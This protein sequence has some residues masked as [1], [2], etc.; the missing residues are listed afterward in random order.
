MTPIE[1]AAAEIDK[2]AKDASKH[3]RMRARPLA[4]N[5][6]DVVRSVLY[7][8]ACTGWRVVKDK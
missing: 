6:E 1:A 4:T 5:T 8:L 3:M 7:S 2:Q